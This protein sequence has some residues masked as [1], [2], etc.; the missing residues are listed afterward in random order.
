MFK[1]SSEK[2]RIVPVIL[3]WLTVI[4]SVILA[5]VFGWDKGDFMPAYFFPFFIGV[6]VSSYLITLFL[7]AFGDLME[8]TQRIKEACKAIEKEVKETKAE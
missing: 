5:F 7:V 4:T 8:N 1:D 3:F 2:I 6:P